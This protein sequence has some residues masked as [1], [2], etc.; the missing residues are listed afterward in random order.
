MALLCEDFSPDPSNSIRFLYFF[1]HSNL[2]LPLERVFII[3]C[4]LEYLNVL[5]LHL[6][7]KCHTSVVFA[8]ISRAGKLHK[9]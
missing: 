3:L 9:I 6:V 2:H 4:I 5:L 8:D 7:Y 1:S